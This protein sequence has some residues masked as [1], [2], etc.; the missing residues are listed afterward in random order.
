MSQEHAE[1]AT[2]RAVIEHL[3]AFNG[4]DTERVLRGLDEDVVWA[5]GSDLYQ[6]RAT[7]RDVFDEWLWRLEPSLDVMRLIVEGDAAAVE[8]VERMVVKGSPVEF[9]IA[10]FLTVRHGLLTKV[11]VFREGSAD[12]SVGDQ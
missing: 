6:G 4:H 3:E 1:A 11:K 2:R 5:T 9:P 10:V 7:L 8:C 12:V